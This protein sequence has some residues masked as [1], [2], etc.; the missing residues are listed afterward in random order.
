MTPGVS[1]DIPAGT[2]F[3]YRC[4]GAE[5][6]RFLCV[7]MPPWPGDHEATIIDGPW[8]PTEP[9]SSAPTH[10]IHHVEGWMP[11]RLVTATGPNP[12]PR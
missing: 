4:N 2:S 8:L 12:L 5:A 3:Q 6:L 1:L 9:A 11:Q 10:G 7:T